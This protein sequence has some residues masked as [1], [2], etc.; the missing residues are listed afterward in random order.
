M[1]ATQVLTAMAEQVFYHL[2]ELHIALDYALGAGELFNI[3]EKS[4]YV[5]AILGQCPEGFAAIG[6]CT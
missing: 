4:D 2:G 5:Q 3:N 6:K 1:G